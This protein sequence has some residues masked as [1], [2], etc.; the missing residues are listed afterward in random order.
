M[1]IKC[2]IHDLQFLFLTARF[3]HTT[4]SM[5]EVYLRTLQQYMATIVNKCWH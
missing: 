1:T 3:C 2:V 4:D 5:Q